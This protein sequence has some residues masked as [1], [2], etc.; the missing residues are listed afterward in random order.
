MSIQKRRIIYMNDEDWARLLAEAAAGSTTVSAI[1]RNATA[2]KPVGA[3]RFGTPRPA[4]KQ[5]AK[6]R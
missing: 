4:P 1:I 2:A 3:E 5:S 6:Q